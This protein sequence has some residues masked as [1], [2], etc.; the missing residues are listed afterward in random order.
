MKLPETSKLHVLWRKCRTCC[1]LLFVT[2]SFSPWWPLGFLIFSPPLKNVHV[3]LPTNSSLSSALAFSVAIF[4]VELC[5]PVAH[6]IFLYI[7]NLW[8]WQLIQAFF[9]IKKQFPLFVFVFIDSLV[10]SASQD[11]GGYAISRQVT[12]SCIWV[13][14][15]VGWL[16]LHWYACGADGRL[17]GS[18]VTWLPKFLGWVDYQI[19]LPMVLRFARFV[20]VELRYECSLKTVFSR[21]SALLDI[22]EQRREFLLSKAAANVPYSALNRSYL[23]TKM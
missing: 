7:P 22:G 19:F 17:V 13:A 23:S 20:R 12:S 8:T 5:W 9:C 2:L 11:A 21:Y 15:P 1:C 18:T 3:V 14:I 16:I 10:V 4:L 6:F